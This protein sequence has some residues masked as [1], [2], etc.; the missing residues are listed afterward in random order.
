MSAFAGIVAFDGAPIDHQKEGAVLRAISG[1]HGGRAA[2]SRLE[3][4]VFAQRSSSAG[5][6]GRGEPQSSAGGDGRT[7]FAAHARLDN[8]E[9]LGAALGLTPSQI[10]RTQDAT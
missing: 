3:G 7:L 1:P 4:A 2:A 6:G 5:I 8:R 9:E 10:V